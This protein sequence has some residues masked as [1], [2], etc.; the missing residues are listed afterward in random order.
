MLGVKEDLKKQNGKK[1]KKD[2]HDW[3]RR[4]CILLFPRHPVKMVEPE[5]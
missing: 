2:S 5:S 1:K 4:M 3:K